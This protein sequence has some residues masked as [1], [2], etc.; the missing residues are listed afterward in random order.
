MAIKFLN[1]ALLGKTGEERFKREGMIL[2]RLAHP[3]IAELIDAGVSSTGQPYLVLEHI[4]GDHIDR[5]C[6]QHGLIIPAR[7]RLFL[8]VLAAVEQAHAN[9]IV[10]RDLKPSNVL[11]RNDGQAKLVD[12]G[13]AKLLES[14]GESQ[15]TLDGG[16]AMTPEYA[17]PEQLAGKPVTTATDI[18]S[19]G[20][21]LYVLFTGH[22]P[23]G[24]GPH[25]P[26]DLVKA[27]MDTDPVPPSQIVAPT[28]S[29]ATLTT[30]YAAR[31]TTTPDKLS[32]ILRGDLDTIVTKAVKK[33]PDER[34]PS[35]RA[36]ADDLNR[37]LRDEPIGARPDTLAYRAGKFVRRHRTAMVASMLVVLSLIL[38]SITT[39][40]LA[41]RSGT[42]PQFTQRRLTANPQDLPVLDAAIS[43]DGK[44]IGYGDQVGIHLQVVETGAF[45]DL[46]LPSGTQSLASHWVFGTW[47]PDSKK[48]LASVVGPEKLVTV[49]SIPIAGGSVHKVAEVEDMS[50]PAKISPNGSAIAYARLHG[51]SGAHEIGP[52][53]CTESPH[54]G[55]KLLAPGPHFSKLGGRRLGIES[56]TPTKLTKRIKGIS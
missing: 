30:N 26:A 1:I 38:A 46:P 32:R 44:Y 53:V 22:H 29:N 56:Y 28:R 41:H 42:M 40:F 23:V 11:V 34:Y 51:G 24:V 20:V 14:E 25:A 3:H 37:Y 18:Y 7:I 27:I 33:N 9:L 49:W 45:Q 43:P 31:R 35:V 2:G 48:L 52:W 13:I 19:L 4:E 8:D 16:R 5:Y 54:T 15:L 36:L 55:L 6:D 12:F 47:Y 39:W 21:L 50:G 17:A 10:H